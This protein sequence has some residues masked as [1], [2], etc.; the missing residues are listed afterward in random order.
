MAISIIYIIK[1]RFLAYR[2]N[3][4]LLRK[5]DHENNPLIFF[6]I[7]PAALLPFYFNTIQK[8]SIS[9]LCTGTGIYG[10]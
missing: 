9:K 5:E 2:Y 1:I 8:S 4:K 3:V 7:G 10:S 6:A